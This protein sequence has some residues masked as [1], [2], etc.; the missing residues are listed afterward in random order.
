MIKGGGY[1]LDVGACQLLI[2]K[3]IGLKHGGEVA[4]FT[5]DSVIF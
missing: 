3:K 5:E 4:D 1:Y 2:D